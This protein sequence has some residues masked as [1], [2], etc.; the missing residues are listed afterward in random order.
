MSKKICHCLCGGDVEIRNISVNS[1]MDGSYNNWEVSCKGCGGQWQWAADN[2][3]GREFYT[4]DEVIDLWNE[5]CLRRS[6]PYLMHQE[7]G[8]PLIECQAAYDLAMEY[9]RNKG[10]VKG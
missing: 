2:F 10:R 5:M 6:I 7:M 9:L 8:V 3:Y 4:K 1:G